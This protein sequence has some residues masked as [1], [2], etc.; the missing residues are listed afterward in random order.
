MSFY[1]ARLIY[2]ILVDD[3]RPRRRQ[4][5]D[6]TVVVF[7]ARDYDH[8][9]ARA[10]ELGHAAETEYLNGAGQTVRWAFAT[11]E[12][13]DHVGSRLDGAEVGSRQHV[14]VLPKPLSAKVHFHPERSRP[15][16]S[17][18]AGLLQRS[19]KSNSDRRGAA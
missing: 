2:Y 8:A 11:V 19:A 1:S 12:T 7:R 14:R 16:H 9:F 10:L 5:C 15:E 3:G 6:E 13:L 4:H 17:S 18:P